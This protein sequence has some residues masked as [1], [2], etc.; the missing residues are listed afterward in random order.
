MGITNTDIVHGAGSAS[1]VS[2][3]DPTKLLYT[4]HLTSQRNVRTQDC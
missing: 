2:S 3:L 1:A 4:A